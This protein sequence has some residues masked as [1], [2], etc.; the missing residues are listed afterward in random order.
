MPWLPWN[1]PLS[2]KQ[3]EGIQEA[4]SRGKRF[5]IWR[6]GILQFTVPV[7][8]MLT[9]WDYFD[10]TLARRSFGDNVFLVSA[11]L[12]ILVACGYWVGVRMWQRFNTL[13]GLEP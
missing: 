13:L 5:V 7:F 1:K 8:L 9:A 4:L 10:G 6:F 3:R 2:S 11:H 12:V